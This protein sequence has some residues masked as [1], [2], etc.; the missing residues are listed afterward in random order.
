MLLQSTFPPVLY[1][2]MCTLSTE[3]DMNKYDSTNSDLEYKSQSD[4]HVYKKP[5]HLD[6]EEE[7]NVGVTESMVENVDC[8]NNAH[9]QFH[10]RHQESHETD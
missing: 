8:T 9:L 10:Q 4:H 1:A 6:K 7:E 2:F 5:D 3:D